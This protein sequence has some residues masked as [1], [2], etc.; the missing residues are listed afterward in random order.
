M[1]RWWWQSNF[2]LFARCHLLPQY[3]LFT[4]VTLCRYEHAPPIQNR[5]KHVYVKCFYCHFC[6]GCSLGRVDFRTYKKLKSFSLSH[7]QKYSSAQYLVRW[8]EIYSRFVQIYLVFDVITPL[9][10]NEKCFRYCISP[11]RRQPCGKDDK[12]SP[13]MGTNFIWNR[14]KPGIPAF[15]LFWQVR[16]KII[17]FPV[18][19]LEIPS[20]L[21]K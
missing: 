6:S 19:V 11:I 2:L 7:P 8:P 18:Q 16:N 3:I 13:F 4:T 15:R 9:L 17:V 21:A 12:I 14:S 5:I 1:R 20:F 10:W